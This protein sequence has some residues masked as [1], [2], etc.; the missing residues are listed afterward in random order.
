MY[1]ILVAVAFLLL[2]SEATFANLKLHFQSPFREDSTTSGFIPHVFGADSASGPVLGDSSATR[3]KG[4][5]AFWFT[6][7][8]GTDKA[9][10]LGDSASFSITICP[11]Y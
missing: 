10:S 8:F 3:M 2:A 11:E 6:Y 1:R 7:T 5:S 9:D 4:E